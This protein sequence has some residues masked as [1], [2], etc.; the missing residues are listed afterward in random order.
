MLS[1]KCIHILFNRMIV[2]GISTNRIAYKG[3]IND[4]KLNIDTNG[5]TSGIYIVQ[6]KSGNY[7]LTE[8]VKL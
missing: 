1:R 5:W 8:K 4:G 6:A 2:H 3:K 7:I